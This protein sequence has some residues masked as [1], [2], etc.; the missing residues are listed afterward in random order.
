MR[1]T[2]LL[3]RLVPITGTALAMQGCS[4]Q[5]ERPV[6]REWDVMSTVAAL[7]I[8]APERSRLDAYAAK[9]EETLK[10]IESRVSIFD[11]QSEI[12]AVNRAAGSHAVEVSGIT[13]EVLRL[14]REYAR[15]SGGRFDP[16][17]LPLLRLW[18]F[19]GGA[20][21]V[22]TPASDRLEAARRL[23]GYDKLVLGPGRTVRLKVA[24]MKADLGGIAKGY[25]VDLCSRR[26]RDAGARD[27]LVNLGGNLLCRGR[28]APERPWTVGVRNPFRREEILG[29]LELEDGLAVATSGN[30]ERFVEIDGKRYAHILDPRTGSPVHGMAGVT[31]VSR[32]AAEADALSTALFVAGTDDAVRILASM[33]DSHALL[34]P[35]RTPLRICLTPG[36][37][38]RFI[39]EPAFEDRMEELPLKERE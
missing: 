20:R 28:P 29:V 4:R 14:S 17:V 24:G 10:E 36:F 5:D 35:D 30:Y 23:V 38:S 12:S 34:I 31:V 16:T 15:I 32:S 11:P 39:P 21:P 22:H 1:N 33:P 13:F 2:T 26:L 8:P 37:V 19:H 25:G 27:F 18:G 3:L 6:T 7:T 9:A